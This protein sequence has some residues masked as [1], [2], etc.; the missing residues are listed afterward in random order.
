MEYMHTQN[1]EVF[2]AKL[3]EDVNKV[4]FA[5]TLCVYLH[6]GTRYG[7]QAHSVVS[8]FLVKTSYPIRPLRSPRLQDYKQLVT[9]TMD[10]QLV[11]TVSLT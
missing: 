9:K 8:F 2:K 1:Q 4:A 11:H 10:L 7:F 3:F 5:L 6:T